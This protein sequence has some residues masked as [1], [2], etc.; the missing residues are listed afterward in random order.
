MPL[1]RRAR[2]ARRSGSRMGQGMHVKT[3][4]TAAAMSSLRECTSRTRLSRRQRRGA[5]RRVKRSTRR[6]RMDRAEDCRLAR[7]LAQ[8]LCPRGVQGEDAWAERGRRRGGG[9][10][11]ASARTCADCT[12]SSCREKSRRLECHSITGIE[13]KTFSSSALARHAGGVGD[14]T[15][16]G[17]VDGGRGELPVFLVSL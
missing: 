14:T 5:E 6:G 2:S 17:K 4:R 11:P 13:A 8:T 1:R 3:R 10:L 7:E 12:A 9:G 15:G 16:G